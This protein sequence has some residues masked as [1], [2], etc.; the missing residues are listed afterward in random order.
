[1]MTFHFAKT[2]LG[3]TSSSAGRKNCDGFNLDRPMNVTDEAS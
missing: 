1:M 2:D 3:P